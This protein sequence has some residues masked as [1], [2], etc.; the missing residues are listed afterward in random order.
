MA[1]DITL[2]TLR[3]SYLPCLSLLMISS[4][5]DSFKDTYKDTLRKYAKLKWPKR[6]LILTQ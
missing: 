6:E 5:K 3:A 4:Y 2:L 1:V